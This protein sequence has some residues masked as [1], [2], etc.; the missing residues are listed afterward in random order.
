MDHSTLLYLVSK[1]SLIGKLAQWTL[2]LQEF[3][4]D[5]YHRPG[6]QHAIADYLSRSESGESED[7]VKDDFP[8]GQLFRIIAVELVETREELEDKWLTDITYFLSIGLSPEGMQRDENKW[9]AVKS[10]SF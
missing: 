4:F 5:I 1:A 3:E 6:V 9:L 2:L 10:Q 8:D 7:G